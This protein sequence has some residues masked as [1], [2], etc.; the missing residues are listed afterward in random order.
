[1]KDLLSQRGALSSFAL[2]LEGLQFPLST[3]VLLLMLYVA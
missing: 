3:Q 1:M 2:P